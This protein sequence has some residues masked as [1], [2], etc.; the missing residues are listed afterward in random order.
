MGKQGSNGVLLTMT[1][2]G[3]VVLAA[4]AY[5]FL[6]SPQLD[7]AST[8]REDAEFA[9][10]ENDLLELKIQQMQA[11]EQE[12]PGWR[13]EIAK[14]SLD[15]PPRIEQADFERLLHNQLADAELPLIDVTYG[16]ATVVDPLALGEF[17]PPS[18]L[19]EEG[20]GA[21]E[22]SDAEPSPS[23][24]P[25]PSTAPTGEGEGTEPTTPS[26]PLPEEPPFEG[27]YGIPVT[28]TTEG[29]PEAVLDLIEAMNTQLERFFTVT[30]LTVG[31]ATVSEETPGRPELTEQDWS[32]Q[33]S[34]LVFSLIDPERSFPADEDGGLPVYTGGGVDNAFEP[35]DGLEESEAA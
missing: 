15:L 5:F 14:I 23:P 17:E 11:L 31:M 35:L 1:I 12:V 28:F 24:S 34:G 7:Q 18:P 26:E 9:R 3:A 10:E 16:R 27:L 2:L 25:E 32:V 4:L 21:E 22:G 8:A 29:D 6:I 33:V 19:D 13:E 20:E 30:N